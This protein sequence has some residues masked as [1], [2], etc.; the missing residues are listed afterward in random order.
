MEQRYPTSVPW[1][2][3]ET[4]G[5]RGRSGDGGVRREQAEHPGSR[6]RTVGN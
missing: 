1:L 3:R 4:G 2:H 6:T 5:G